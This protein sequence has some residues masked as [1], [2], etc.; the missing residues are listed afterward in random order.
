MR[1]LITS[2][3]AAFLFSSVAVYA[4]EFVILIW[5]I[6]S[7]SAD[8][9]FRF[10]QRGK[11]G[12][13]DSSGKIVIK[14]TLPVDSN[15]RGEFHEGLLAASEERNI[16]RY[17]DKSGHALVLRVE[18]WLPGDFS[19]GLA[20]AS[21]DTKSPWGFINRTGAFVIQP[22]FD[23]VQPFSEGL[24]R[25]SVSRQFGTTGYIDHHGTLV[26]PAHLTKGSDFHEGLAAAIVE[27]PCRRIP[28]SSCW[29]AD[30]FQPMPS[31]PARNCRFAYIDK[32]G[33]PISDLR[34]DEAMDF[35]E[36]LAAVQDRQRVGL[37]RSHRQTRDP[38][39]I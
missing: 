1:R 6:E 36:G 31:T 9:L 13:I 15:F 18:A 39:T 32:T 2:L 27:G 22:Q 14:P 11:A 35:S 5:G 25:V 38:A 24:A 21:K 10:V 26:I 23:S 8:P 30:K 7:K 4:C 19:E 20:A 3:L 34:L 33:K 28:S 37:R 29:A 12:Y 17:V 16:Y